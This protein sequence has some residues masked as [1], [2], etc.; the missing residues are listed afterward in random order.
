LN[1]HHRIPRKRHFE[2][3][4]SRPDEIQIEFNR[5]PMLGT[6]KL[7]IRM[8]G[9]SKFVWNEKSE[10]KKYCAGTLCNLLRKIYY[11]KSSRELW[12][13]MRRTQ[14]LYGHD[15]SESIGRRIHISRNVLQCKAVQCRVVLVHMNCLSERPRKDGNY[16]LLYF[17][18]IRQRIPSRGVFFPPIHLYV[19]RCLGKMPEKCD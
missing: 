18:I 1:T 9:L 8:F 12:M 6:V 19:Y 11:A 4:T 17:S 7:F 15:K 3:S 2:N 5:K 14:N 10:K 16:Y 13:P